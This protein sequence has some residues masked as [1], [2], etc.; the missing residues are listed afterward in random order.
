M[1]VLITTTDINATKMLNGSKTIPRETMN[2]D[3]N[4]MLRDSNKTNTQSDSFVH[5][6]S[7][8]WNGNG[9]NMLVPDVLWNLFVNLPIAARC[10]SIEI[11]LS[12]YRMPI[13]KKNFRQRGL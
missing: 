8:E 2:I 13:S 3:A 9:N 4:R 6:L 12:F 11:I 1:S 5:R 7:P 10:A